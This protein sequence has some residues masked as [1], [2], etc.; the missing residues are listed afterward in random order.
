MRYAGGELNAV[1]KDPET[2]SLHGVLCFPDIYDIGMSHYGSQILYHIVNRHPKWML[3]RCFAPAPDAE[4]IMRRHG[5]PLFALEDYSPIAAAEWIG[6]SV[7]YELQATNILNM[8]DLAGIPL[9]SSKRRDGD[10]IVVAG[11][12]CVGNPEP[13]ADFIDAF[14]IGDGERA[15]E[16]ICAALDQA[17]LL[18]L[19]RGEAIRRLS[20]LDG[21]Y[22]PALVAV[23]RSGRFD[24][25]D[26]P[27]GSV[28][29]AR[30]QTLAPENYPVDPVV[31][32]IDVVHHRLAVEVMRGCTRGC[33]F[34]S[35][36]MYY[37]P[38]R[39]RPPEEIC[40][41]I[42]KSI[43]ATGWRDVGL[44]SL[45]SAD[46]GGLDE[47]LVH[48]SRFKQT[49]HIRLSMPSTRIDA[50]SPAQFDAINDISS[51][52]SFTIAPE[53]GSERLRRVINKG[54]T[55]QQIIAM[56]SMLMERNVQTLKLYFMVGLPTETDE[57]IAA[58]ISLVA[59][60][61]GRARAVSGRKRIHVSLSPFSPKPHTPF[62]WEAAA[63]PDTLMG[64]SRFIKQAL[65]Q[66]TN[67]K[68]SYRDPEV[69]FL[70]TVMA[71]GDRRM[72]RVIIEAWN[73]GAR[74]DGW[75]EHFNMAR[76]RDAAA[77]VRVDLNVYADAI[78]LEEELPWHAVF[79][80]VSKEF[81]LRERQRAYDGEMTGD[82]RTGACNQCGACAGERVCVW[83]RSRPSPAPAIS[84]KQ[85][86][87]A[88]ERHY[89]RF[90]YSKARAVRFLGH[91][92]MV[93]VFERAF[94]AAGIS[95]EYSSGFTVHPRL[96]FGPPLPQGAIG[97]AELFDAILT[98][99]LSDGQ[100]ESVNRWL[101]KDLRVTAVA[102]LPA[103]P[104]PVNAAIAAARYRF[105]P[106]S[107]SPLPMAGALRRFE[108]SGEVVVECEKEGVRAQKEIRSL[109]HGITET[110]GAPGFD[111]TLSLLPGKTCKPS[112]LV[113]ALFP[114]L[115][116]ADFL[117]TR[118]ECLMRKDGNL[119]AF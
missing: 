115:S 49:A 72:S 86:P 6:F 78:P 117:I 75:E 44:L 93:R 98:M 25:P 65:S 83:T 45:S 106:M 99:P 64:K 20:G 107:D 19:T 29:T 24:V 91:L 21:V 33:R 66:Q 2:V 87:A 100:A 14:V 13:L 35:A 30:V 97:D 16:E 5:I 9:T 8:L 36:G 60:I 23:R 46:Y 110:P 7:Q 50:L 108:A 74:F 47:L 81:L 71:R 37:R 48:A 34:C 40:A 92:D 90:V 26:T 4:E 10:P 38:L 28:Q 1:R 63:S 111:A 42:E 112:E 82:C 51:P 88:A 43:A 54:L 105:L 59:A 67:V 80:G 32:L 18:R 102:G 53:A 73:R 119:V 61:S 31:P 76:W 11:G 69:T 104:M 70:E 58:I 85:A 62:Q 56:A 101:P 84:E 116:A 96:A 95:L 109:V 52:S 79:A 114:G 89:Y 3:S 55:D 17:R 57:D 15:I 103:K 27:A 118:L 113:R 94:L 41:Q 39:E 12:P 68:V 77:A 22:V